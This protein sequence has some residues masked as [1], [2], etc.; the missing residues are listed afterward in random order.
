MPAFND[1]ERLGRGLYLQFCVTR[2][3]NGGLVGL[4]V[5]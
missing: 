5:L 4:T 1:R 2:V 3:D